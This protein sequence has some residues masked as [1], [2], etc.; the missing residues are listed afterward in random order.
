[1]Y[2]A[3]KVRAH[4]PTRPVLRRA[5]PAAARQAEAQ[6]LSR[7][8][9]LAALGP[10]SRAVGKL[11]PPRRA[12]LPPARPRAAFSTRSNMALKWK[13]WP[14]RASIS[15]T[16]P[17][18]PAPRARP[19]GAFAQVLAPDDDRAD[20]L[21]RLHAHRRDARG[22]GRGREPVEPGPR[23]GAAGVEH[24]DFRARAGTVQGPHRDL[25]VPQRRGPLSR[26][27][28][29]QAW[30]SAPSTTSGT[31]WPR[32]WRTETG[33]GRARRGWSPRAR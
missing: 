23:A 32:T 22:E 31:R 24:Q 26:N 2:P 28:F 10:Q 6:A 18:P 7:R 14:S 19:A 11:H 27:R 3:G 29:G 4:V 9:M 20:L 33:A 25:D 1:M 21:G 17:S 15:M 8:D 16:C 13:S 5:V 30:C 12:R